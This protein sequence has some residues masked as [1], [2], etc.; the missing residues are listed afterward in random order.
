MGSLL[1]Q[2]LPL[3]LG[4]AL[5]PTLLTL[6]VLTLAGRRAPLARAWAIAFG[7]LVVVIA[8]CALGLTVLDQVSERTSTRSSTVEAIVK[9]AAAAA[10]L[11]LAGRSLLRHPTAAEQ[12]H[13]R[14]H[15]RIEKAGAPFFV[16]VGMGGM[17]TNFTTIVLFFP[18]LHEITRSDAS[19]TARA[20][21]VVML[22][23]ITMLP[24]V[25][26]PLAV[27]LLGS[28]AH[29]ALEAL[30]RFTTA[31]RRTISAAI[32]LAF[33]AYLAYGAVQAL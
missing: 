13:S 17:L 1:T 18:A 2:V 9:F 7:C 8:W 30:N 31:H 24:V 26:P 19:E 11:A 22:A 15:D 16:V 20:I 21:V 32:C 4:A 14:T 10:L 12:H 5:S 27:A 33:A 28:R 29:R 6:Q 23:A 3:A 25:L